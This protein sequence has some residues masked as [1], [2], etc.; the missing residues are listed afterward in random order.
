MKRENPA[1][2]HLDVIDHEIQDY[3]KDMLVLIKDSEGKGSGFFF[4]V[5]KLLFA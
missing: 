2:I 3:T 1:L 4:F 5:Q